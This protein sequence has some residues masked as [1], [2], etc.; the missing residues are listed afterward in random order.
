MMTQE[1]LIEFLDRFFQVDQ[2]PKEERGGI[3]RKSDRLI[4]RLGLALEPTLNFDL[5]ITNHRV[6]ALFIHRPWQLDPE[7]DI[8]VV[9]YHLPFDEQLTLGFNLR[10]AEA[11]TLVNAKPF[12][13]KAGRAIGMIGEIPPQS[14]DRCCGQIR[15]IFGGYESAIGQSE[16]VRKIAIVGAMNESL[17][18]SAA[19][20]GVEVYITGQFRTS[21]KAAVLETGMCVIEVGH[22]RCEQWGL[23]ALS[24]VLR[25]RWSKLQIILL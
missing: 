16:A 12:G 15:D 10:L 1:T 8:G 5:W 18:R 13:H 3:Y 19:A 4:Q 25:E 7:L 9:F 2:Y 21:A 22:H 14:S 17:I 6:D 24:G 23:K 20:Q 11:L